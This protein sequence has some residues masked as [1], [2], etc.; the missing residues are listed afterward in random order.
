M[1][2]DYKGPGISYINNQI[3]PSRNLFGKILVRVEVARRRRLRL[4]I[5]FYGVL[6]IGALI[7]F[8]P[9]WSELQR[10]AT[11]SGFSQF[12]SLFATD[13]TAL[14]AYWQDFCF[15]LL[16]SFP[17]IG[18]AGLL[19][20]FFALLI[21]LRSLVRDTGYYMTTQRRYI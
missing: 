3:K 6:F 19:G 16:E 8:F 20:I 14:I 15:S 11:Q 13:S 7:G 17:V 5:G 18:I 10:E 21:S 2:T 12:I 1:N 9:A 4:R